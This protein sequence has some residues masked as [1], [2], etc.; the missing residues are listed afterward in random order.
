MDLEVVIVSHRDG[1]WLAACLASLE[2]AAGLCAYRVTIVENGGSL[3]PLTE[4]PTRRLIYSENRGFG[5]ANNVGVRD[6]TAD[7][8]LFLNP[9]TELVEGTL[10]RLA[11]VMRERPQVGL[12]YTNRVVHWRGVGH[13][14]HLPA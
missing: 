2:R 11:R 12:L 5:A 8:L 10:E 9:D 13:V 4:C 1:R 3:I 6:S 7:V 14:R